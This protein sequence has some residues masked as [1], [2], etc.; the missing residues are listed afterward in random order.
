[1]EY[2]GIL[3]IGIITVICVESVLIMRMQDFQEAVPRPV[4]SSLLLKCLYWTS[5]KPYMAAIG[6]FCERVFHLKLIDRENEKEESV[7]M[8]SLTEDVPLSLN[9]LRENDEY[10][11]ALFGVGVASNSWIDI[12]NHV[13]SLFFIAVT[14]L[15]IILVSYMLW[16]A[17]C[18]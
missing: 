13:N 9:P 8:I 7:E 18:G 12:S 11:K 15:Y 1:M 4:P 6:E 10:S 5:T 17:F 2:F 16:W 3:N 14:V